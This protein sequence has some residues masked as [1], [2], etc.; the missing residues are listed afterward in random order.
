MFLWSWLF[1]KKLFSM[2]SWQRVSHHCHISQ[3]TWSHMLTMT[4]QINFYSSSFF[5]ELYILGDS[6]TTTRT[7]FSSQTTLT[8][9]KPMS[10]W[11]E[12]RDT[13]IIL[14]QS[15]AKNVVLSKQVK[16]TVIILAFFDQQKGSVTRNKNNW[17][18]YTAS[19]EKD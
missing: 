6:R 1:L 19:K 12:K 4:K 8:L 2:S 18:T 11:R 14:E 16:N 13:V 15:F 10:F 3:T 9:H 7:R 5:R 17:A